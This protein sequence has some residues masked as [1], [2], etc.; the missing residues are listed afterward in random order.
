M[1]ACCRSRLKADSRCR[2]GIDGR[3]IY[4]RRDRHSPVILSSFLRYTTRRND[5]LSIAGLKG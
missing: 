2:S 1:F 3:L 4:N 5:K